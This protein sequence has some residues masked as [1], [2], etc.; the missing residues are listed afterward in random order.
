MKKVVKNS[1]IYVFLIIGLAVFTHAVF[2]YYQ[3]F[4]IECETTEHH[5]GNEIDQSNVYC[6]FLDE[7]IDNKVFF[8][9]DYVFLKSIPFHKELLL[10]TDFKIQNKAF[11]QLLFFEHDF[12]PNYF[13]CI[14][15]TPSRGSP[16]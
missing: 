1:I 15:N 7:I 5:T 16:A 13:V 12:F 11:P 3:Y 4:N 8:N 14:E 10:S 9:S 2:P 6:H